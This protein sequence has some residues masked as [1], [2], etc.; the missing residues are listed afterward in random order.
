MADNS[1]DNTIE[2][3]SFCQRS[4]EEVNFLVT[5]GSRNGIAI[6]NRCIQQSYHKFSRHADSRSERSDYGKSRLL[7]GAKSSM[8]ASD[9]M[10]DLPTPAELKEHL[11]EYVIGQ[12]HAKKLLAVAVYNHY[13]R[14]WFN[15]MQ[16]S[17]RNSRKSEVEINKSN[18]L[19][20]GPTGSG[21]T[22]LAQVLSKRLDVPFTIAD[23]TT[24]TETGYVGDDVESILHRL[25]INSDH[26]VERAEMGIVYLDEV[27]KISRKSENL[28][29]TRDVSGEGVQQALLKL[30]EGSV[31]AVPPQGGRK[32]P[33]KET[34]KVDTSNILFICGGAF[35]GL[36]KIIERRSSK[37]D[38]SIGFSAEVRNREHDRM[39]RIKL[40]RQVEPD[41]LMRYGLI[42]EL[43]GRLP[44][45]VTLENLDEEALI[46]IL[47]EPRNAIIKQYQ[48]MVGMEGVSLSFKPD[49][50]KAIVAKAITQ[51]TGARGLRTVVETALIDL[52][53]DL[54]SQFGKYSEVEI[55]KA[56]IEGSGPP[57][58]KQTPM[59]KR[60]DSK[61]HDESE[62][63]QDDDAVTTDSA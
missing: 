26:N 18:V 3:C 37:G 6:C 30:I 60:K 15:R 46:R 20:I 59:R 31:V 17:G 49:A 38:S 41:D 32:H 61:I 48:A 35:E 44:I 16:G 8:Q 52:M 47:T 22:L 7:N 45:N 1:S 54:P 28:S 10:S 53:Y 25:L 39:E 27:D 62:T 2:R 51:G 24:I 63:E 13:K 36:E 9:Y 11:D 57:I 21:K 58:F 33:H 50:L 55:T 43:V 34:L 23:A 42:P 12:E 14:L 40:M 19:M 56:M 4:R 29:I 5:G